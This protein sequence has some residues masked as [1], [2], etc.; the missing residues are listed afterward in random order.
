MQILNKEVEL[1]TTCRNSLR[2]ASNCIAGVVF[3]SSPTEGPG[4]IWN[5]TLRA[6]DA[7]GEKIDVKS[8]GNDQEIYIIPLQHAIDAAIASMN[9][10]ADRPSIPDQVLEY[11]FTSLT[12]KERED[13]IRINFMKGVIKYLA[14][15][16]F[17]A[18]SGITYHLTGMM[19]CQ[20]VSAKAYK[21]LM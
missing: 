1:L 17:I 2:G 12:A 13:K 10:T 9:S 3:Y 14:V 19:V 5:Y 11:V 15:A 21:R 8:T 7:L 20:F 16:F 6:D 4:G 18:M